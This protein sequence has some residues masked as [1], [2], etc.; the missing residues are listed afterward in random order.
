MKRYT[1][2][3]RQGELTLHK[4]GECGTKD[5][6]P[7]ILKTWFEFGKVA[8]FHNDALIGWFPSVRLNLE[9]NHDTDQYEFL[10]FRR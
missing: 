4:I 7:Y 2:V 10:E 6:D 5:I 8:G 1:I 3:D 9:Y